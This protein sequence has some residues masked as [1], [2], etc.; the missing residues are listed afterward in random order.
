M[1][2]LPPLGKAISQTILPTFKAYAPLLRQN[3][4][5]IKSTRR[6]TFPYGPHPRQHLD[7]Y[8]PSRPSLS[9]PSPSPSLS[10][11]SSPPTSGTADWK[12]PLPV[13]HNPN[14]VFIFLYGGGFVNGAKILPGY[15][16]PE[17]GQDGQDGQG[18]V[19][20]N[21]G[22]FFAENLGIKTVVIDYRLISHGAKFPSGGQDLELAIEWVV[23][24]LNSNSNS[25]SPTANDDDDEHAPPPPPPLD[26]YIMGNSA[27]GVH[28]ATYLLA[29]DFAE[30][31]RRL[32]SSSIRAADDNS[33]AETRSKAHQARLKGVI[34]LSVPFHFD[35]ALPERKPT[36]AA[37]YG[38][39]NDDDV[40]SKAPLGLLRAS[41]KG[42]GSR[43]IKPLFQDVSVLVLKGSLDPEDEILGPTA[44]FVD[45]WLRQKKGTEDNDD[46]S[47]RNASTS[48]RSLSL[49]P[50]NLEVEMMPGQH[51]HISPV[52]SLGTGIPDEEAWGRRVV[53]FVATTSHARR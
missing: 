45:E 24:N 37:Y 35:H 53:D 9:S 5:T 41:R 7:V 49:S 39:D 44:D 28:L 23:D 8:T 19:Y 43:S 51:N 4:E 38:D 36:L 33:S 30:S 12:T 26:L 46:Q 22:H 29:P 32:L 2:Q 18:L 3:S 40:R 34:F 16:K 42:D 52:L 13:T 31:R 6:E 11:P 17:P 1:D 21:L 27:G 10:S 50:S 14:S 15:S 47:G 25:N 48:D 20:A